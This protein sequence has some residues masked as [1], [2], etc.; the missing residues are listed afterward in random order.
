MEVSLAAC[1]LKVYAGRA[2]LVLLGASAEACNAIC[3]NSRGG[4][5]QA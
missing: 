4:R 2:T 5:S 3:D 1:R